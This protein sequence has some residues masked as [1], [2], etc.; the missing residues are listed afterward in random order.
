MIGAT[1]GGNCCPRYRCYRAEGSGFHSLIIYD[2]GYVNIGVNVTAELSA[3]QSNYNYNLHVGW[4]KTT[5]DCGVEGTGGRYDPT[6][7]CGGTVEAGGVGGTPSTNVVSDAECADG[8]GYAYLAPTPDYAKCGVEPYLQNN[9]EYGDL[10]G[11]SG[12]VSVNGNS[13]TSFYLPNFVKDFKKN[14]AIEFDDNGERIRTPARW[15][16]LVMNCN[17]KSCLDRVA[18]AGYKKV[19]CNLFAPSFEENYGA[20]PK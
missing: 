2:G 6:R 14:N 7:A 12:Q 1:E 17:S 10:T 20:A 13:V 8:L 5:E 3:F 11:R 4:N 16:S 18:C 19:N 9:C 15:S